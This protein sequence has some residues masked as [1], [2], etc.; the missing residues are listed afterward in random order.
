MLD[1]NE[2]LNQQIEQAGIRKE[3]KPVKPPVAEGISYN[4][5]LQKLVRMIKADIDE[6]IVPVLRQLAPQYT[7]DGWVDTLSSVINQ[8]LYRWSSPQFNVLAAQ[9]AAKFV[10]STSAVT[11]K[12]FQ[13]SMESFGIDVYQDSPAF[14][15]FVDVVIQDNTQLIKSIP[16]Q[17]LERVQ[18]IVYGNTRAGLRPSVI[19]K[20]LQEQFGVTQR[21]A[22]MI[23]RDQ[24]TK[25]NGQISEKRQASAGF[26][27]FQWIDSDDSRVRHR[28]DELANRV[29][30]YGKGIYR[31]DNLPLSDDGK[32]ISPGSDFQCRCIARPVSNQEVEA[33]KKA[34]RVNPALKR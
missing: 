1:R 6:Q 31:W 9:L 28:H 14:Q 7:A 27:Y 32:P 21:R 3:A 26:E 19:T 16:S 12:R 18:S 29:T 20:Q 34:G 30:A 13:A 15:D 4:A 17:Y 22:K 8:V 11:L 25:I 5:E 33:N 10:Q 2:L 23:A 24:T